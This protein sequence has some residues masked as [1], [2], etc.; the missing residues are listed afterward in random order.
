MLQLLCCMMVIAVLLWH[1]RAGHWDTSFMWDI[2]HA[3]RVASPALSTRLPVLL[4]RNICA[5]DLKSGADLYAR[6]FALD[7]VSTIV[8]FFCY[9]SL[10]GTGNSVVDSLQSSSLLPGS[11][12]LTLVLLFV[13]MVLDRCAHIRR[14]IGAKL[15]QKRQ[16]LKPFDPQFGQRA[17]FAAMFKSLR[18]S[19]SARPLG[20]RVPPRSPSCWSS[21]MTT[22]APLSS[23]CASRSRQTQE[24]DRRV[25]TRWNSSGL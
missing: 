4:L 18:A 2:A 11:L 19:V 16:Q 8:L 5:T 15:M 9:S 24:A 3:S 22:R 10:A 7:I 17:F 1:S 23:R 25:R 20:I 6:I 21:S 13:V 14:S 12:A